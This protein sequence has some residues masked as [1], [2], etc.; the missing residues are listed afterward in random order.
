PQYARASAGASPTSASTLL[1]GVH[2]DAAR[3]ALA[4]WSSNRRSG[5]MLSCARMY[6][7]PTAVIPTPL[8]ALP[9]SDTREGYETA[10]VGCRRRLGDGRA[11]E[12]ARAHQQQA[13]G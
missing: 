9:S 2:P 13:G 10:C 12:H 8:G 6:A 7:T 1:G 11:P 4:S 5:R 3:K